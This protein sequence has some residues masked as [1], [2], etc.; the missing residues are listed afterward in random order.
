MLLLEVN[1]FTKGNPHFNMLGYIYMVT[2]SNLHCERLVEPIGVVSYLRRDA[3]WQA[4][5]LM[6]IWGHNVIKLDRNWYHVWWNIIFFEDNIFSVVIS[7]NVT[8]FDNVF[9]AFWW[10]GWRTTL[11]S[12]W[13][14]FQLR[15]WINFI[16]NSNFMMFCFTMPGGLKWRGL[17]I[18]SG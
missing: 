7:L 4:V 12:Q 17:T 5:S 11:I 1:T 16:W 18:V 8:M 9:S 15:L 10:T 13:P 3:D 6:E 2:V 14:V